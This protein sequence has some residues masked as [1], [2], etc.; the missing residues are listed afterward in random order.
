MEDLLRQNVIG[1]AYS[2]RRSD[3]STESFIARLLGDPRMF[4]IN[5]HG[6]SNQPGGGS[7][8]YVGHVDPSNPVQVVA[9]TAPHSNGETVHLSDIRWASL[10]FADPD[11]SKI[12]FRTQPSPVDL[13]A[14]DSLTLKS[15]PGPWERSDRREYE[16]PTLKDER[17]I[18]AVL[19]DVNERNV[20][21]GVS[22][23][24]PEVSLY[25]LAWSKNAWLERT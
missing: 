10:H 20:P 1:G 12:L 3:E 13:T 6:H 18:K 14:V 2:V 17:P 5:P 25:T 15:L 23:L 8:V 19:T 22:R 24:C 7:D 9:L 11:R 21:H 16:V 4:K